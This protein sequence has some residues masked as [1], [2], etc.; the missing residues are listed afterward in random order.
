[1][2]QLQ[3]EKYFPL[4]EQDYI[5][6]THELNHLCLTVSITAA[7]LWRCLTIIR[8]F[9]LTNKHSGLALLS[10]SSKVIN[11][12]LEHARALIPCV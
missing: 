3:T 1:M 10:D 5:S 11:L 2:V 6:L 4:K 12:L 8:A 9:H 7:D